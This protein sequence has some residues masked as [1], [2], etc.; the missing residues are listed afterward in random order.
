MTTRELLDELREVQEVL[1]APPPTVR[2]FHPGYEGGPMWA[3]TRLGE[4]IGALEVEAALEELDDPGQ[5]N[6]DPGDPE[7]N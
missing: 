5:R 4:L 1:C 6:E 2:D 7:R 3:A